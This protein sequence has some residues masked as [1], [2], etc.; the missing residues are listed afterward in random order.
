MNY[1]SQR[2]VATIEKWRHASPGRQWCIPASWPRA[3]RMDMSDTEINAIAEAGGWTW[4]TPFGTAHPDSVYHAV[5][6]GIV[7]SIDGVIGGARTP[8]Q[9]RKRL[10]S[11]QKV[12]YDFPR[13]VSRLCVV[14]WTS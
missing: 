8:N 6:A 12:D 10:P 4:A 1:R 2:Q 13:C 5:A 11:L 9:G 7:V 3:E 14:G